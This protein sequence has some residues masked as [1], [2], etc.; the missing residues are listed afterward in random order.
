MSRASVRWL[1]FALCAALVALLPGC[2]GD[3]CDK[4]EMG[5]L[6]MKVDPPVAKQVPHTEVQQG[7]E[8][9]DPYFWLRDDER[10]DPEVLAYLEA[11]NAYTEA[12]MKPTE[13][14]QQALYDE[15]LA[16]IKETDLGVPER[17]GDYFY[18]ERTEEGK[19]Y[20]QFCRKKGSLDAEEELILD[21]NALAEG[22]DYFRVG[23]FEVMRIG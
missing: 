10:Q 19:Q 12:V 11:E 6:D 13:E 2:C 20:R 22:H 9:E 17:I 8:V 15:M 16:R 1:G 18:Y 7:V 14:F 3:S 23:A 5:S 21:E 4:A